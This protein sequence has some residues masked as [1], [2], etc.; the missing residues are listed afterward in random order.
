M[1]LELNNAFE[2]EIASVT[3]QIKSANQALSTEEDREQA[4]FLRFCIKQLEEWLKTLKANQTAVM[5]AENRVPERKE[6]YLRWRELRVAARDVQDEMETLGRKVQPARDACVPFENAVR[7][8]EIAL[9]MHRATALPAYPTQPEITRRAEK[10]KKLQL[11]LD[12]ARAELRQANIA[13]GQAFNAWIAARQKYDDAC[14]A[15]RMVRLPTDEP[16]GQIFA[17][18]I[19]T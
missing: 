6:N 19:A 4:E 16:V 2:L 9:Q 8:A 15:E 18:G 12:E 11:A 17:R 10:E 14:F 5:L 13:A 7:K 3:E 1:S